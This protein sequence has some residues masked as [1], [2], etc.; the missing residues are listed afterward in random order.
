MKLWRKSGY[1]NLSGRLRGSAR[2]QVYVG[3]PSA[4]LIALLNRMQSE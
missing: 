4:L 3:Y 1:R 2:E